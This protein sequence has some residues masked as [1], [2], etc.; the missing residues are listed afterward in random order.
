M[1][2]FLLGKASDHFDISDQEFRFIVDYATRALHIPDDIS[3]FFEFEDVEEDLCGFVHQDECAP[4]EY[5]I[6]I[7]PRLDWESLVR[8][9]FHELAHVRQGVLKFRIGNEWHGVHYDPTI[10]SEFE[11]PWEQEAYEIEEILYQKFVSIGELV[12]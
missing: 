6:I 12:A 1:S 10:I 3:M 7:T 4:H 5:C 9:I 2:V 11:L 8:T